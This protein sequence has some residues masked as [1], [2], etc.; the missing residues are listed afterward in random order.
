M[1]II[2]KYP[3]RRLYDTEKSGY[4]TLTD[5]LALVRKGEDFKVVDTETGEDLTRS[6]L[7]QII[8]EQ[9]SGDK[10]IFTTDMLTKF[11][12]LY[13]DAAQNVFGEFLE[14]NMQ[15]FSEQQKR[16]TEGML[17]SPLP[18]MMQEVAER[19]IAIWT[20]MQKSFLDL[21]TGGMRASASPKDDTDA[22]S[23]KKKRK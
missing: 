11:I 3:N 12:R 19:N 17:E 8:L 9:E 6:V 14:K 21:A 15:L 22:A 16:F 1:R 23:K 2:K 5:M 10:P 4:I 18:K 13:D 7:V 20:D